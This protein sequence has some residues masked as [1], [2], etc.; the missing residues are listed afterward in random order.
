MKSLNEIYQWNEIYACEI[1]WIPI[2]AERQP[3]STSAAAVSA[4]GG[5]WTVESKING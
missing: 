1:E 4:F 2:L 5:T 3:V